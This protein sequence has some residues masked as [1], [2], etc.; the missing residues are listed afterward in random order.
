M[1]IDIFEKSDLIY[2]KIFVI[3]LNKIENDWIQRYFLETPFN[4]TITKRIG[5]IQVNL[6]IFFFLLIFDVLFL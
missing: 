1:Y 3:V 4:G 5:A 2:K 6:I